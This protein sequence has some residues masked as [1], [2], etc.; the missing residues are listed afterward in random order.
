MKAAIRKIVDRVINDSTPE[1]QDLYLKDPDRA[2][3]IDAAAE[4][5]A[6]GSTH[7]EVINDWRRTFDN[8]IQDRRRWATPDRVVAA[9]HAHFDSI[10]AWHEIHGSLH[11][12]I[13]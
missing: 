6:E 7:Y 8:M 13:G 5:G 4:H 11:Q 3:R 2:E 9:V 12:E 10:E 1:I